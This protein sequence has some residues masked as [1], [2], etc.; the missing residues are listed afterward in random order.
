M[1][2]GVDEAREWLRLAS[3]ALDAARLLAG[4]DFLR[5]AVSK[6]YYA[7]FYAAKAAVISRGL[8]A[9][10]HSTV[11][12]QFGQHFAKTG[13]VQRRLHQTLRIAFDERQ[14]ADYTLDWSV[15]P[16]MVETRLAEAEE[17]VTGI[18]RLLG[19]IE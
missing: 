12:S 15:S 2:G 8:E 5:D 11:I 14:L 16:E 10:K 1:A 13:L 18:S 19:A 3:E 7:M 6:S 4:R 17:F 9:S